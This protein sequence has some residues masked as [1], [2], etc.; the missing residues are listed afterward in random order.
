MAPFRYDAVSALADGD[1]L[2]VSGGTGTQPP[3][4]TGSSSVWTNDI[5][6]EWDAIYTFPTFFLSP[7]SHDEVAKA[8][9]ASA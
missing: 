4:H 5:Q 2:C 7:I 1:A 3:D 9:V 8:Q 6:T